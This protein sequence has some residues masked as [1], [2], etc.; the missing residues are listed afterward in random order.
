MAMAR[1]YWD[2]ARL[3]IVAVGDATRIRDVLAK[4]GMVDMFD[5][6]GNVVK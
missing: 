6:E 3:H 1:K 5:A 2:P 4:K